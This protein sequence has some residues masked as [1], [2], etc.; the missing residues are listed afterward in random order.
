MKKSNGLPDVRELSL[1]AEEL[2]DVGSFINDLDG[3][4]EDGGHHR[5]SSTSLQLINST[6]M[7]P[8]KELATQAER[9]QKEASPKKTQAPAS[10]P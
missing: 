3:D 8:L 5:V 9:E 10:K 1:S 2:E 4:D 6:R 7:P